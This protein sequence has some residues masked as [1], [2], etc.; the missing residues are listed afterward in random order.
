MEG[1]VLNERGQVL[2][3]GENA[4]AMEWGVRYRQASRERGRV[5]IDGI[6]ELSP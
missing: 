1:D 4:T 5:T 6:R 2:V 3:I